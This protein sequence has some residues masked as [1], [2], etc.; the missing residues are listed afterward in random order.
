MLFCV[1]VEN[2]NGRNMMADD[3]A[4]ILTMNRFILSA[5][6]LVWGKEPVVETTSTVHSY[7]PYRPGHKNQRGSRTRHKTQKGLKLYY[8]NTKYS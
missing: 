5:E 2:A 1:A 4:M 7:L 8:I 3:A 6:E